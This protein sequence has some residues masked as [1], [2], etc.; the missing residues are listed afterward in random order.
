MDCVVFKLLIRVYDLK[1]YLL[2]I[3]EI[4]WLVLFK[5]VVSSLDGKYIF[6]ID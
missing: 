3:F 6:I 2:K 1:G 5:Y 4:L